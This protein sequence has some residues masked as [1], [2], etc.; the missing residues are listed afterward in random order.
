MYLKM[1]SRRTL[2]HPVCLTNHKT[3]LLLRS[4]DQIHSKWCRSRYHHAQGRK[5]VVL[6]GSV[7]DQLQNDGGHDVGVRDAMALDGIA[8]R[9][10]LEAREDVHGYAGVDCVV[11]E[12]ADSYDPINQYIGGRGKWEGEEREYRKYGRMAECPECDLGSRPAGP[13]RQRHFAPCSRPCCGAR[14]SRP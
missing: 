13:A 12:E 11:E 4:V 2:A 10:E 6:S 5:V 9:G 1:N 14:A 3:Q 8:E 7:G